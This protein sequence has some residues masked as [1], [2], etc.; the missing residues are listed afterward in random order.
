M[1][2]DLR[3]RGRRRTIQIVYA[4]L[5]ILMAAGLILFGVGSGLAGGLIDAI[6][7]KGGTNSGNSLL[8]KQA[9]TLEKR[10]QRNPQDAATWGKLARTQFQLAAGTIDQTTGQYT[11]EGKADLTKAGASWGR[12]LALSPEKPDPTIAALMVQAFIQLGNASKA[13]DAQEIVTSARPNRNAYLALAKLAY[14]AGQTR[15]GDLAAAKALA[16]T[17][18]DLRGTVKQ[19]LDEAK[20]QGSKP[21]GQSPGA[22]PTPPPSG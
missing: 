14:A 9:D 10:V 12:Y 1:L 13:A 7:D 17:P 4:T 18:K 6:N 15:K 2:F 3:G 21:A 20:K 16:D 5:A 19:Q 11:K 22:T 8:Q